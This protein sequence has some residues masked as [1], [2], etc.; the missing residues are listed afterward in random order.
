MV[1]RGIPYP[2]QEESPRPSGAL[3]TSTPATHKALIDS[4]QCSS[5]QGSSKFWY[6]EIK[7]NGQ[8]SF[9]GEKYKDHYKVFR[10]VVSDY[11]ADNTGKTNAAAAIQSAIEGMKPSSC[12]GYKMKMALNVF[13][14]SWSVERPEP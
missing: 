11:G 7:H 4:S 9:L 2:V 14:Y 10:N 13:L 8:S 5:G 1:N 12:L 3:S 6:E